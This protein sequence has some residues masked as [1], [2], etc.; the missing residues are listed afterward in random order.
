MPR[1]YDKFDFDRYHANQKI[2][3]KIKRACMNS[4]LDIVPYQDMF[5]HIRQMA[6]DSKHEVVKHNLKLAQECNEWLKERSELMLRIAAPEQAGQ[7]YAQWRRCMLFAA[8]YDF[9]SY[10]QYVELDREKNKK[11]YLPRRHYLLPVTQAYQAVADGKLDLLTISM[12]K[13]CGKSQMGINFT[14]WLS[15]RKPNNASLMEGTGDS[16][17]KSFYN[18]CLEYLVQPSDY[19]YYDIFP[20]APLVQTNADDKIINLDQRSRFPTVMCRSIDSRQ[21]GLSEAT[22]LLY[23]DDC[24]EGHEEAQNRQRLEDKWEVISGDIMGRAIEGTP[25]VF[26]GTRYSLYDPIGKVQD[27]ARSQ[28][29]RWRALEIPALDP[30]TDESNF[31]YVRDGAK[32][33]TTAYFR[34]QRDLLSAEQWEAEFQQE[35]FE[36][37]GLTFP[38]DELNYF[39]ELPRDIDPDSVIAVADTAQKGSDSTSMPIAYIYG[40]D[41]YIPD[42]VFDNSPPA[43]T[44]P[45]C[46]RKIIEH[47]VQNVTFESNN[48]GDYYGKDVVELCRAEGYKVGA[49]YKRTISNKQTRIEMS[50]SNIIKNFW[51]KHPSTYKPNSQYA[52]FM[53][54]LTTHTRTGKV[55]HDDAPDSLS[56]LENE[57]RRATS[58]GVEIVRRMF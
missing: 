51:F 49:R 26:C 45:Q 4:L 42:V 9:D 50:S 40:T 28:N 22:N 36:A 52:A 27:Y 14:L 16:L 12:P 1:E 19:L 44:Q 15:G 8:T 31:E 18:G 6:D 35:P 55:Q 3:E 37:K 32:V 25:M 10:L 43:V 30:E 21:V 38:K 56:L 57:T 53:R 58:G 33:F 5:E 17:V 41:I 48:A 7:F 20:H 11:F 29:W 46:A 24:V 34:A 47:H 2:A 13:R 39:Y 54:E 23:L